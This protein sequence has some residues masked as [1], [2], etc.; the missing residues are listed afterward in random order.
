MKR[1]FTVFA[2]A[3]ASFLVVPGL[4]SGDDRP[5]REGGG[6]PVVPGARMGTPLDMP[7]EL[8]REERRV[9]EASE[10]GKAFLLT[11]AGQAEKAEVEAALRVIEERVRTKTRTGPDGAFHATEPQSEPSGDQ[12][13][14]EAYNYGS[15]E[16]SQEGAD[17]STYYSGC[18]Y[19]VV[20]LKY[21]NNFG[22]EL[23]RYNQRIH[24]CW[25]WGRHHLFLS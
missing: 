23:W 3:A 19:P 14:M 7:A 13:S 5:V 6:G 9:F 10:F 11:P 17:H 25:T 20:A 12:E 8:I 18:K 4:A 1:I 16:G 24:W 2:V 21:V 15:T 22:Q